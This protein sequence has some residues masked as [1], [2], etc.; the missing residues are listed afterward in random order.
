MH[1][2]AFTQGLV[3]QALAK[4]PWF[5]GHSYVNLNLSY[6]MRV[7]LVVMQISERRK[8]MPIRAQKRFDLYSQVEGVSR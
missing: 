6:K 5:G 1:V 8:N 7:S 2:W 3:Y 4:L